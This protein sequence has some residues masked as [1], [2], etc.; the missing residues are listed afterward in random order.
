MADNIEV[1]SWTDWRGKTHTREVHQTINVRDFIGTPG[2]ALLVVAAN[3]HFSGTDIG[4]F[5]YAKSL[6]VDG[7]ERGRRW[8][9]KRIWLF[10]QPGTHRALGNADG[11][12]G[13][14]ITLMAEHSKASLRDLVVLLK[15]RG[16]SR[17]RE[18]VRMNRVRAGR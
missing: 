7:V 14:A 1:L 11:N 16:I 9:Q 6:K 3:P 5:L 4:R 12:D 2:Y 8:L 13:R 18:W 15:E 17:S 10:R